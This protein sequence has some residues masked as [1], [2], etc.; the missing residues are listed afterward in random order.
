M[1]KGG[2]SLAS[3]LWDVA[4]SLPLTISDGTSSFVF[5]PGG[6]P[7]EQVATDNSVLFYHHDQLGSTRLLTD[8][9]GAVQAT[10]AYDPYGSL[11]AI[12]GIVSA[13]FLFTGQFV[14]TESGLYY[15]R[16][17]YYD[18]TTAQFIS[19]DPWVGITRSP[20]AYVA[21]NPLNATDAS[22]HAAQACALILVQ[23]EGPGEAACVVGIIIDVGVVVIGGI[24]GVLGIHFA[25]DQPRDATS[26]EPSAGNVR[27][28]ADPCFDDPAKSPGPDWEWRGPK[29]KGSWYNPKTGESLHP[30]LDHP[31]P[32]GPHYDYRA[33]GG[34]FYRWYRNGDMVLKSSQSFLQITAP[35]DVHNPAPPSFGG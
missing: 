17:R 24:L 3:F 27:E 19:T 23:P 30:D 4:G 18:R 11:N 25:T 28:R 15:L 35:Y 6:L 12:T 34:D 14:D 10:Y 21:G 2:A 13:P 32:I 20:Y 16:S 1:A 26:T 29:D 5:G 31:D 8:A 33:P 9:T 7:V 22:G